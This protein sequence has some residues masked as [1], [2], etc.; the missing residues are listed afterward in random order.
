MFPHI[1]TRTNPLSSQRTISRKAIHLP[2]ACFIVR[3][4]DRA[5]MPTIDAIVLFAFKSCTHVVIILGLSPSKVIRVSLR[6]LS[7]YGKTRLCC[8][9]I[10]D[11]FITAEQFVHRY[12]VSIKDR[13]GFCI[14]WRV[15]P[16]N[17]IHLR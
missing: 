1:L 15:I 5:I 16:T 17:Q 7:P 8:N 11:D 4:Y 10:I 3:G 9:N 2:R 6:F 12:F 14:P 13:G